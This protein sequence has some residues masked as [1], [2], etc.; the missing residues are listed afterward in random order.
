MQIWVL[1]V[2]VDSYIQ[3]WVCNSREL[4]RSYLA[5]YCREQWREEMGKKP[6]ADEDVVWEYFSFFTERNWSESYIL[7]EETILES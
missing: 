7:N 4:A 1:Q 2:E 6:I 5:R 3:T